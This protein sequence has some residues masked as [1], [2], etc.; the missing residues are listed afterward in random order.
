MIWYR[1]I[2]ISIK[3]GDKCYG[4]GTQRNLFLKEERKRWA[5]SRFEMTK[6]NIDQFDVNGGSNRKFKRCSDTV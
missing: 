1:A 3:N 2:I 5:H 4:E 6:E